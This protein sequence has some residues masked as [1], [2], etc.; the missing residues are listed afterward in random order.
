MKKRLFIVCLVVFLLVVSLCGV[1]A[2]EL[3][4]KIVIGWSPPQKVSGVYALAT[5]CFE[6]SAADATKA[7]INVQIVTQAP[8]AETDFATQISV[9]EDFIARKVD[10]II[11]APA[12]VSVL[13]NTF[14]EANRAGIPIIIVNLLEPIEGVEIAS[15]IGFSNVDAGIISG[16]ALLDYL[17]GPGVLGKGEKVT[18][19]EY[20]DKIFWENLYKDVDLEKLNLKA[21]IAIIEGIAGGFY[22]RLRLEGFHY[23]I[24]QCK[25]IK[26]LAS[27]PADWDRQK[28]VKVTE[29]ILQ[30][31]KKLDAIWAASNE[32]GMGAVYAVEAAGR[33]D[34]IKVL[35]N[36][37]TPESVDMI[38]NGRLLAETW[39]GFP[40]WG[41]YGTR[42]A[43][44][45][46]LGLDIPYQFDI[47]P[48]T[49]YKDNADDFYPNTKLE[50]QPWKKIIEEY[51]M[52]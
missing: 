3:P 33:S 18:P 30:A 47:R 11:T 8:A 45:A 35:C 6:K 24:D 10:C 17:G 38:R 31:N 34:E 48:R 2:K 14:K 39:H 12:E 9:I 52:K 20:L 23:V 25:G 21:D 16:Y 27:Q 28:G 46:S 37:G 36:D 43:I 22:S 26:V 29:N 5:E 49:E 40:E 15:Y 32:M 41:W 1:F 13:I 51:M 50:P 44:M 4:K 42:F 19:P 7:G